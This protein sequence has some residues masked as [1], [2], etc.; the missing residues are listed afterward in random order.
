MLKQQ[1][2]AATNAHASANSTQYAKPGT[3]GSGYGA[4]YD[5]LASS[6]DY[7][8]G[9]YI[10]NTQGQNKNSGANASSAGTAASDLMYG[11]KSHTPIGKVNVST[12]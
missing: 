11:T 1:L 6:Q 7:T 2:P 12:Q 9:A 8:K 4:N 3:Y 5:V 10:G